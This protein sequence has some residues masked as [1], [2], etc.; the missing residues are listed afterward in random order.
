MRYARPDRNGRYLTVK[1]HVE[2]GSV[3]PT[4]NGVVT[5]EIG[6]QQYMGRKQL[7]PN[8]DY[9]VVSESSGA[10]NR[11]ISQKGFRAW[12][13]FKQFQQRVFVTVNTSD[14]HGAQKE[15]KGVTTKPNC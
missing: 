8:T 12:K 3:D 2:A 14:G 6:V 11:T 1:Q 10:V 7:T 5:R 13:C 15:Y 4:C 9:G